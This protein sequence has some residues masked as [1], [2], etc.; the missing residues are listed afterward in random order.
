MLAHVQ[1][2]LSAS[3]EGGV[4]EAIQGV[5]CTPLSLSEHVETKRKFLTKGSD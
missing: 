4:S 2:R 1:R 5:A 3:T